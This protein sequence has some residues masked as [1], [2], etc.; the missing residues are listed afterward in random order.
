MGFHPQQLLPFFQRHVTEGRHWIALSGG[1]D[2]TVLLHAVAQLQLS[3]PLHA[4]HVHHGLQ[5][6]A[7]QWVEACQQLCRRHHIAL[8]VIK[9]DATPATGE[10]PE[11]AARHARYDA[12]ESV[13]ERGD[14]LLT[15]HHQQDQAETFLMRALRGAGPRGLASMRAVR[16]LGRGVLMR[17]LLEVSQQALVEYAKA[18]QLNWIE[19]P[20]NALLEADRN[21]LRQQIFPQLASRW[22]A[23]AE[24][25]SRSAAHCE[26]SDQLQQQWGA[27]QI[28]GLAPGDPLPLI[29]EESPAE[30]KLRIR[31]WLALNGVDAPDTKHMSRI[32]Q[33]LIPARDDAM[34]LVAWLAL[35]GQQ[36]R[37]RRFQ[38]ALYL[39]PVWGARAFEEA[40]SWDLSH[41]ITLSEHYFL[42]VS[43]VE[44]QGLS[45]AAL[46]QG[47]IT[48]RW[49]QGGERCQPAG[50]HQRRT[51]K[52]ILRERQIPPWEREQ[53]PLLY[54]DGTIA[55]AIGHFICEG[56]M[57]KPGEMGVSIE[58]V[59]Q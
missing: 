28:Q 30:T 12:F 37:L 44:E 18:Q 34:P 40:Q 56:F 45:I 51:L 52:N 47:G 3:T 58:R 43:Q 48:L 19:D 59:Q 25:L 16:P 39:Q 32:L 24:T 17:P 20:S 29:E 42:R 31:S 38:Q 4:I 9:V 41:P 50:S 10:S 23:I 5:S 53:I 13:L 26:E 49:R 15:A 55:A 57:A 33:E 14:Q 11:A 36:I 54:V 2:S 22:P 1:V 8:S 46:Q 35:D 6:E 7:D 21:F 27:A